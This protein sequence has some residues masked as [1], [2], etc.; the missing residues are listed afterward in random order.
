MEPITAKRLALNLTERGHSAQHT[1]EG[2]LLV[3]GRLY[4]DASELDG[5]MGEGPTT[6]E[7]GA[8]VREL[9]SGKASKS[10]PKA[11]RGRR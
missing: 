11:K 7:G 6:R 8:S 3:D 9:T 10:K 2:G 1:A 5:L 4:T